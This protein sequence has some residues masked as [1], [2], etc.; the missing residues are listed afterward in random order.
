MRSF[1]RCGARWSQRS[2]ILWMLA[3]LCLAILAGCSAPLRECPTLLSDES[4]RQELIRSVAD[5]YP[6]ALQAA[7]RATVTIAGKDYP[8]NGFVLTRQLRLDASRGDARLVATSDLGG[9]AFDACQVAGG[10]PRVLRNAAGL[11]PSWITDGAL[12]DVV[13]IYLTRP[14]EG[15]ALGRYSDGTLCL[16]EKKADELVREF[17]FAGDS[18]RLTAYCLFR[19]EKCVYEVRFSSERTLGGWPRA[20]PTVLEIADRKLGYHATV[21]VLQL[22]PALLDDRSFERLPDDAK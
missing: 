14:G 18:H 21:R 17:L 5:L 13:V 22:R 4:L 2:G 7:H 8:L 20:F 6:A 9:M 16:F 12:R 3:P 10:R 11:R 19:R 15:A 1:L